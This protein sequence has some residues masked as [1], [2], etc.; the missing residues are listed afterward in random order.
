MT[1]DKK[2]LDGSNPDA[3]QNQWAEVIAT[4]LAAERQFAVWM[5]NPQDLATITLSKEWLGAI[6][7]RGRS[8]KSRDIPV[9]FQT[10]RKAKVISN[11]CL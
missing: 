8:V 9:R 5:K 6:R 10:P 1:A 3:Y 4:H 7:L 11:D 2:L